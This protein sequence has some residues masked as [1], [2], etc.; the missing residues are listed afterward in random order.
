MQE[1]ANL[2]SDALI[3][4][5]KKDGFVIK[6]FNDINKQGL[7]AIN[8]SIKAKLDNYQMI[9]VCKDGEKYPVLVSLSRSEV[10]K[11]KKAGDILKAASKICGGNGGGRPDL[12]Q[13]SF[14]D[15]SKLEELK[16]LFN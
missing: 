9:L 5:I 6:Y 7:M 16:G 13:G 12:A 15:I 10:Q 1:I 2:K 11:G 8:D 14:Q 4:S 3:D